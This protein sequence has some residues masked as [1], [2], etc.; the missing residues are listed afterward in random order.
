MPARETTSLAAAG[1][2]CGSDDIS[3]GH[4]RSP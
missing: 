3:L 4:L 1:G 2:A